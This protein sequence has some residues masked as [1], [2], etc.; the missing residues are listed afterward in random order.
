MPPGRPG[1]LYSS[2][3]PP[4][5]KEESPMT[6]CPATFRTLAAAALAG[7]SGTA[8]A[9]PEYTFTLVDA[10]TPNYDLRECYLWDI[11]NQNVAC[12]AATIQIGSSTTYTGFYWE[13]PGQKTPVELSWPKAV[14]DNGLMC[15]VAEVYDIPAN[16]FTSMPL[17]PSTF[18]PLA[19]LGANNDGLAV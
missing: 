11:N 16:Q 7:L 15:G 14:N 13:P 18:F 12:G 9:T 8:S 3:T 17:L 5:R 4:N 1:A 10:F 2:W 6:N 19:L